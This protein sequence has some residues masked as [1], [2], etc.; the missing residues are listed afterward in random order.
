MSIQKP[1]SAGDADDLQIS[2]D[3]ELA[4]DATSDPPGGVNLFGNGILQE[5]FSATGNLAYEW[6]LE[7][8][9]LKWSSDPGPIL[10]LCADNS[11]SSGREYANLLEADNTLTRY[12][13]VMNSRHIDNGSGVAYQIEYAIR[14]NTSPLW[15]EDCGR[16]F[17]GPDGRPQ[18]AVGMLRTINERHEHEQRL[19]YLSHHDPLTGYLNRDSLVKTIGNALENAV[20]SRISAVLILASVDNLAYINQAF[21]Y[22]VGDDV[23]LKVAERLKEQLRSGDAIG[24]YA[25]N[26]F[27]IVINNCTAKELEFAASRLMASVRESVIAT[28]AG[29]VSVTASMGA[30]MMPRHASECKAAMSCA[31]SALDE[32]KTRHLDNFIIYKRSTERVLKQKRNMRFADD[33]VAALNKRRVIPAFQP[34][35]DARTGEIAFHE[36]LLRLENANGEIVSGGPLIPLAE[37]LGLIR[38]VDHRMLEMAGTALAS[39]PELK[40]SL[41]ISPLTTTCPDWMGL[42]ASSIG[43]ERAK[44][45]R[46]IIE[47]T[48]TAALRNIEETTGFISQ[49]R[50]MGCK[51]A[52]DDFGAG[53]TS[54]HNLKMLEV[55]MVK[56]DGSF[57]ENLHEN[58]DDQFFTRT[59]TDLAKNFNLEIVAEWVTDERTAEML[60]GWGVDYLQ[61]FLYGKPVLRDEFVNPEGSKT[62]V[63]DAQDMAL[64]I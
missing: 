22:D 32:S 55:D 40:L 48:E 14:N 18:R 23:I 34:I 11:L 50:D 46:L 62:S 33:I 58:E 2:S 17:A 5:I 57:I 39:D 4:Q 63:I 24:R 6:L 35:I 20:K 56:L 10:Q 52:I 3:A 27:G 36:C 41:N 53:Y 61:G 43:S 60:R 8:D 42:L 21:G 29:P 44:A 7:D 19:T 28:R 15:V 30:V 31:E 64:V 54:F 1:S 26:K 59:L 47:I 49:V 45:R 9:S 25:G 13:A 16:W 51:V 12:D 37:Q 38:L